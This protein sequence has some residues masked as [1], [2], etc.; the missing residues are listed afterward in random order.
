MVCPTTKN[1]AS[2]EA[3]FLV[4]FD[5]VFIRIMKN[6]LYYINNYVH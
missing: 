3:A 4:N 2:H 1:A 5:Q 6:T